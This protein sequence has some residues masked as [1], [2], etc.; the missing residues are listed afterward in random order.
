M[1]KRDYVMYSMF[2]CVTKN[3]EFTVWYSPFSCDIGSERAFY[4]EFA[5]HLNEPVF[6][7]RFAYKTTT[8]TN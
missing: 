5:M 3:L 7:Q 2:V 4:I 6:F 1:S 8:N